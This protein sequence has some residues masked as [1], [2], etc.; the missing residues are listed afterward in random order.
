MEKGSHRW[1]GDPAQGRVTLPAEPTYWFLMYGLC[2]AD[3]DTLLEYKKIALGRS[4]GARFCSVCGAWAEES[5]NIIRIATE[6]TEI[7]PQMETAVMEIMPQMEA[8]E[9]E[10]IPAYTTKWEISAIW[11]A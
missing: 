5:E 11:L 3:L 4:F 6:G 9:P 10:I 2:D 8:A 7:M 1:E